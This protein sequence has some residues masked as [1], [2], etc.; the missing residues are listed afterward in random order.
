MFSTVKYGIRERETEP[1]SLF[2]SAVDGYQERCSMSV[3]T[4]RQTEIP[5]QLFGRDPASVCSKQAEE[6][7]P[8]TL[9]LHS[10]FLVAHRRTSGFPDDHSRYQGAK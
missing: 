6:E 7:E 5:V 4:D 8:A 3:A 9:F 10:E 2:S 1:S